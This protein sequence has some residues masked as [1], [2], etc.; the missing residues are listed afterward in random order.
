MR[1]LYFGVHAM[2]EHDE[3]GL[4]ADMGHE[5]FSLGS[6][7]GYTPETHHGAHDGRAPLAWR[8]PADLMTLFYASGCALSATNVTEHVITPAFVDAFDVVVIV[9]DAHFIRRNWEVL[10]RRPVIWRTIGQ[11]IYEFDPLLRPL[12]HQG[13][14]IV[15]Y[16]PT[17]RRTRH[18]IGADAVIR[19]FGTPE[20]HPPWHGSDTVVFTAVNRYVQRYPH[21]YEAFRASL[22]GIPYRLAG[23]GNDGVLNATGFITAAA[24]LDRLAASRAYFHCSGLHVP[25][26]LGFIEAWTAGIPL[27]AYDDRRL[28]VYYGRDFSEARGLIHHGRDGF[29]AV[30][31]KA[32]GEIFRR[33]LADPAM[34]AAVGAAGLARAAEIFSRARA[35]AQW[36][37]MLDRAVAEYGRP[38]SL[39]GAVRRLFR[40]R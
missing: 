32:A 35:A 40:R 8:A 13:L 12:R 16:A 27:V 9:H 6:Y 5:V 31:A 2:L 14:R 15:R 4:F 17:E 23:D 30:T 26:T 34:A 10:S 1:I 19:F 28:T 7:F 25:Y 29:R 18:Y 36:D 38:R 21:E 33:L 22:E 39:R 3:V 20:R 24:L 37:A 11:S